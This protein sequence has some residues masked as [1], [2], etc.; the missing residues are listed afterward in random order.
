MK[1]SNNLLLNL[2]F[3]KTSQKVWI[4]IVRLF[5]EKYFKKLRPSKIGRKGKGGKRSKNQEKEDKTEE[6]ENQEKEEITEEEEDQTKKEETTEEEEE[7]DQIEK[8]EIIKEKEED[9][10]RK[11]EITKEK[12]K[13]EGRCEAKADKTLATCERL[14]GFVGRGSRACHANNFRQLVRCKTASLQKKCE[15]FFTGIKGNQAEGER[16]CQ[17]FSTEC[18]DDPNAPA[19]YCDRNCQRI[20][21]TLGGALAARGRRKEEEME[22]KIEDQEETTEEDHPEETEEDPTKEA[23]EI[24][25]MEDPTEETEETE[26]IEEIEETEETDK[27]EKKKEDV[28][29]ER[30]ARFARRGSRLCHANNFRQLVRCNTASLQKKCEA[31]FTGIKGNKAQGER[32][33]QKFSTE[34]EDDPNAPACYCDRNCQ[35]IVKTL[36]GALA[37][38]GRRKEEEMEDQEETTEEGHQEEDHPE[39]QEETK[40]DHQEDQEI[41][42]EDHQEETDKDLFLLVLENFSKKETTEQDHPEDLFFHV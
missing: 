6:K 15:A 29:C 8:E 13:E 3:M 26:E 7:E 28:N 10:T 32:F 41:T 24:E 9:Q 16:F 34:C 5:L 31:F 33:C 30:V 27:T 23:E 2:A 14:A 1:F 17:K 25:E 11:E 35:R 19:C 38:R 22:E 40:E 36:G 20:V 21:K 37:A 42:K 39:D 12:R 18:E 4:K